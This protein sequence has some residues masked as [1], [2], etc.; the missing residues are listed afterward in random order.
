M[1]SYRRL[2]HIR[3]LFVIP[4]LDMVASGSKGLRKKKKLFDMVASGSKGLR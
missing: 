4:S 3:L 1:M 2:S